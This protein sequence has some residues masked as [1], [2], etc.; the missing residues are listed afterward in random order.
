ME[1]Y[2]REMKRELFPRLAFSYKPIDKRK[3]QIKLMFARSGKFLLWSTGTEELTHLHIHEQEEEYGDLFKSI[4]YY[5]IPLMF[6]LKI[7]LV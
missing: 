4:K 2:P 7:L 5:G 1:K 3:R 6:M